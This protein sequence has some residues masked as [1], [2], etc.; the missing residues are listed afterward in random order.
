MRESKLR[1]ERDRAKLMALAS[2]NEREEEKQ[3]GLR[4]EERRKELVSA[5]PSSSLAPRRPWFLHPLVSSFLGFFIP[6]FLGRSPYSSQRKLSLES[7]STSNATPLP[8]PLTLSRGGYWL[9]D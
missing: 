5:G 8:S 3:L 7:F 1:R 9:C 6:W 4:I 2:C